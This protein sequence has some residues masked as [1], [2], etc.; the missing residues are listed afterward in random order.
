MTD[1]ASRA[2]PAP[3]RPLWV[4]IEGVNGV[5]KSTAARAV[6][7]ALGGRCLLL[8]E[9][10]DRPEDTLP[11]RVIDALAAEGDVYLRTGHPVAETLALLAL[12]VR[13]VERLADRC[14]TGV[15]VILE[16]RGPDSVAVYQ[17][18]ILA[19]HYGEEDPAHLARYVLATARSW[20]RLPDA[21]L[22]LTG[23]RTVCTDRFAARV[24]R[25]LAPPDLDV[26][27]RAEELYGVLAAQEPDRYTVVNTTGRS[28]RESADAVEQ[29]VRDL[30]RTREVAHV[31]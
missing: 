3:S 23:D 2:D 10:T 13:E 9:L 6:A 28:P 4:S 1:L 25:A 22:W 21:T 20:S 19:A 16:D 7:A 11:G 24:G 17:A 5:G 30:V 18:A 31:A 15:D 12:K 27:H 26:I 29:S 8:D 14:P